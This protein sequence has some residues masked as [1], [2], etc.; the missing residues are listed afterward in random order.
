[1]PSD[2]Q[3]QSL[4]EVWSER[5]DDRDDQDVACH[6]WAQNLA[7]RDQAM[8]NPIKAFDM[9]DDKSSG[10]ERPVAANDSKPE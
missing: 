4:S 7:A 10:G 5:F 9:P 8:A 6:L 1:M 3:H 2:K